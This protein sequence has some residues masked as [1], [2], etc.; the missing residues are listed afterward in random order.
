MGHVHSSNPDIE[1]ALRANDRE[2]FLFIINHEAQE[3]DTTVR[4]ADLAFAIEKIADLADN[5][6]VPFQRTNDTVQLNLAAPI[7]EIRLLHLLPKT[8]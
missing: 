6:P 4:L 2:A 7:G 8:R 1:A 3:T 5:R